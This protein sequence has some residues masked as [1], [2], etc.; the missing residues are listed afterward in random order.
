LTTST[1]G[2]RPARRAASRA[3]TST[4]ITRSETRASAAVIRPVPA[5]MSTTRAPG[6]TRAAR[7]SAAASAGSRRKCWLR[8]RSRALEARRPATEVPDHRRRHGLRAYS[9]AMPFG[10]LA[11]VPYYICP[12]CKERSLDIDAREGFSTQAPACR[13]CGFGFLFELLDDYYPAPDT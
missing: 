5:P 7:T 3:S 10:T 13:H 1:F 9:T 12:K 11:P 8:G 2:Q 4:A 6:P